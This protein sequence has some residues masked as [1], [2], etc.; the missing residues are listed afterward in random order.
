MESM[1][2]GKVASLAGIGVETI[3]YYERKG[4]IED[5]PRRSSGYREYPIEVVARLRFIRKAKELG[6]T[7][8]EIDELLALRLSADS[9]CRD[10]KRRT[11]TKIVD[12]ETKITALKKMKTTLIELVEACSGDGSPIE[13]CP[14]LGAF[15]QEK[16]P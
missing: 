9:S 14:I 4:L 16:L 13:H 2:I 5:P 8:K 12:M 7:L 1:T 15:E 6:F 11:L 3:R 10:V